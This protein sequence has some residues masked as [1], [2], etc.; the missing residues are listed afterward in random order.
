MML[1]KGAGP[2]TRCPRVRGFFASD[3]HPLIRGKK[4]P[5]AP[6][7]EASRSSLVIPRK[8]DR[9]KCLKREGHE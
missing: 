4:E 1:A 9:C 6:T 5:A 8:R 7:K 3:L 2:R